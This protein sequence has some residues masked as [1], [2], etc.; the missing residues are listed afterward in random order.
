MVDILDPCPSLY[1]EKNVKRFMEPV[2][3]MLPY[4]IDK[5]CKPEASQSHGLSPFVARRVE[6][7]YQ[8]SITS[9]CGPVALEFMEI[10]A[11]GG[12]DDAMG[13]MTDLL[14][15]HFRKQY[16]MDIYAELV[17]PLYLS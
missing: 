12:L 17:V 8:N 11:N 10:H 5:F 6:G 9:D 1:A 7:L 4:V 14:V 3:K 2:L 16:A 13:R 15:D